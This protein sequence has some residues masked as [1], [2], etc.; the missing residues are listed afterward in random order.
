MISKMGWEGKHG[1]TG[2]RESNELGKK[3]ELWVG[4]AGVDIK[5]LLKDLKMKIPR[6]LADQRVI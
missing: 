1:A 5:P 6:L 4:R 2:F 3:W